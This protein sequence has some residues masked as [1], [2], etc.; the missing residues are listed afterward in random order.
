MHYTR[1][2]IEKES[3]EEIGYGNIEYNLAESSVTDITIDELQLSLKALKLEYI[4]HRGKE[5][6][7]ELIGKDAGISSKNILLTQGAAGALFIINTSMLDK[8]DHLIV[9]HP[10]YA[11]NI[12][13]PEAI[14]CKIT[15]IDILFEENWQLDVSRIYKTIAPNTKIISITTPHNPT[16]MVVSE[17]AL[18][19]LINIA[20]AHNIYLLV[21]ETY[22]DT[23]FKTPYSIAAAKSKNVI[24]VSSLSKAFGLPG[25]RTGWIITENEMLME[26]FLA[27]K[28]MIHITNSALDEE[29]AHQFYLQKEKFAIDTNK[30]AIQN[31]AIFKLWIEE[32]NRLECI[33]PQGGVVCFPR[34]KNDISIDTNKF[35]NTLL[36]QYKTMVGPGHWFDMPDT[37]MR[38]GFG[39]TDAATLEQGLRNI[40]KAID[41]SV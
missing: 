35:Y 30:K 24:T 21:D 40:S 4:G 17:D 34:F 38:I 10:N 39:W 18:N 14:G 5:A 25:L 32:E 11:A 29:V 20:E 12:K 2:P 19:S 7:R 26:Q 6:F 31:F 15:Y 9:V 27:A 16:G 3:P 33:L 28:E 36:H 37:Y 23:C 22:R 1:M 13:V 41:E 8:E